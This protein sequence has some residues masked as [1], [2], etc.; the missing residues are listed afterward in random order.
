MLCRQPAFCFTTSVLPIN[1]VQLC[2]FTFNG[3]MVLCI[4]SL[5]RLHA[6][7]SEL[8]QAS[9]ICIELLVVV[10]IYGLI[11]C[12]DCIKAIVLF[13]IFF[14]DC[15]AL[16]YYFPGTIFFSVIR[17]I[18]LC[19]MLSTITLQFSSITTDPLPSMTACVFFIL[20]FMQ[21]IST[22]ALPC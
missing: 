20:R 2:L 19:I 16:I 7:G 18:D 8:I 11:E 10:L 14:I 22:F 4:T 17:F 21:E 12:N 13:N 6:C 5:I 9:F 15:L 3:F 1:L